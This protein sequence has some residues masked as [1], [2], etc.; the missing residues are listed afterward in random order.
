MIL[1]M[2]N[3]VLIPYTGC[4]NI[5]HAC[6]EHL[7]ERC[8][9]DTTI[10]LIY[11]S[12]TG[13][14]NLP[15]HIADHPGVVRLRNTS[16]RGPAAARNLGIRWCREHDVALVILLDSDCVPKNDIVM[17][18]ITHHRNNPEAVCIGGAIEGVGRGIWAELDKVASWFTSLPKSPP[19]IVNGIY[20][21]PTTNMSIDLM[22]LPI[23]GD[24]FDGRLRTGEDVK[25]IKR[26]L[27][28]EQ[29]ILY[30]PTP[31]VQHYDREAFRSFIY[32]QYCWGLHAYRVRYEGTDHVLFRFMFVCV[33]TP[34]IPLFAAAATVINLIPWIRTSPIK[35]LVYVVPL[36]ILYLL[37]GL[38]VAHG[39]IDPSAATQEGNRPC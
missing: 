38:A 5:L 7:L 14:D 12:S 13:V 27:N 28:L 8:Q 10:L 16:G 32:H 25:F 19:R 4:S 23:S 2:R 37:K 29:R 36:Y 3:C 21:I 39:T 34:A 1:R 9:D 35:S 31:V 20:H 22:S 6:L 26:L 30:F 15:S 11:D 18:H 24:L 17:E 33:F